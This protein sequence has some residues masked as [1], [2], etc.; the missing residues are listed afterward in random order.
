[1]TI[2]I[3]SYLTDLQYAV[4]AVSREK[5]AELV[6][7]VWTGYQNDQQVFT[8]GNGGSAASASHIAADWAKGTAFEDR[9]RLRVIPLTD[10]I[11]LMTAWANDTEYDNIFAEQLRNLVR[12]NDVVIGISGSGNSENVLRAIRLAKERG[13]ITVGLSGFDGGQL[14][15]LVDFSFHI[16]NNSMEQ[17]ED[18]HMMIGHAVAVQL[19]QRLR[20]L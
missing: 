12:Q 5:M 8:M 19:R 6:D 7:I 4:S 10:N 3:D 15:Q 13:A 18:I 20:S 1:M 14:H 11:P 2:S 17:V 9:R 16:E